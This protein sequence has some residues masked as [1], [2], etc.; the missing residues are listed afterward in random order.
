[1]FSI[2]VLSLPV[3]TRRRRCRHEIMA[4]ILNYVSVVG[5]A[6]P[7]WIARFANLPLDRANRLLGEMVSLGLLK[8]DVEEDGARYYRVTER[9]FKYVELYRRLRILVG[10]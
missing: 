8:E 2:H 6:R 1:M 7:S 4:D 3:R 9:G 10:G 5:R